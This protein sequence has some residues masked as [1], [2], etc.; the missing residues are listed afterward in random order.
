M[1][2]QMS[3]KELEAVLRSL[4]DRRGWAVTEESREKDAL[5]LKVRFSEREGGIHLWCPEPVVDGGGPCSPGFLRVDLGSEEAPPKRWGVLYTNQN[6]SEHYDDQTVSVGYQIAV[7][8]NG[9]SVV[10]TTDLRG[11]EPFPRA[12]AKVLERA[13][14]LRS[15]PPQGTLFE[16]LDESLVRSGGFSNP[17]AASMIWPA[18]GAVL[19]AITWA[20]Q[21]WSEA[22]AV[23]M[24]FSLSKLFFSAVAVHVNFPHQRL[25]SILGVTPPAYDSELR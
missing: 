4:L 24:I 19:S 15:G 12:F 14:V 7:F 22:V 20:A 2:S 9:V 18:F 23:L 10:L 6:A 3:P 25:G 21:S 8:A 5:L 16:G 1:G 17:V 11:W 13:E